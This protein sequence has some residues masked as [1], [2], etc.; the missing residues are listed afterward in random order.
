LRKQHPAPPDGS[1]EIAA[2]KIARSDIVILL[3]NRHVTSDFAAIL[4]N[5][6]KRMSVVQFL[7]EPS[8]PEIAVDFPPEPATRNVF[9]CLGQRIS[10]LS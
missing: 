4:A 6:L 10:T 9:E 1:E 3:F 7:L 2:P 8:A 5:R